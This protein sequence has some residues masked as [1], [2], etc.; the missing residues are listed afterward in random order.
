MCETVTPPEQWKYCDRCGNILNRTD[1]WEYDWPNYGTITLGYNSCIDT[2]LVG[3]Y[4]ASRDRT[5]LK[6]GHPALTEFGFQRVTFRWGKMGENEKYRLCL[7]CQ[8]ELIQMIGRF[9]AIPDLQHRKEVERLT[10]E[11]AK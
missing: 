8:T 10:A 5:W 6:E 7:D 3:G 2:H 9:F 4:R 1:R 11:R